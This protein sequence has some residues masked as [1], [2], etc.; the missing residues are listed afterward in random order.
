VNLPLAMGT[1]YNKIKR[2]ANRQLSMVFIL[3]AVCVIKIESAFR[4]CLCVFVFT[5]ILR[6]YFIVFCAGFCNTEQ[7]QYQESR[8]RCRG[9]QRPQSEQRLR[10]RQR[11][12]T[13][14]CFELDCRHNRFNRIRIAHCSF[15]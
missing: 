15:C 5:L 1:G 3:K 10:Q 7:R 12:L 2:I 14:R 8:Y 9:E 13:C 11:Q 6:H 4:V